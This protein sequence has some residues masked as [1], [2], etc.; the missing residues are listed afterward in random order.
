VCPSSSPDPWHELPSSTPV[1]R[2]ERWRAAISLLSVTALIALVVLAV[3]FDFLAAT[4]VLLVVFLSFVL[5]YLIAPAVE[6][7]RRASAAWRKGRPVTREVAL[8][9]LYG[10]IV[11]LALPVWVFAGQRLTAAAGRT[12]DT[13]PQHVARF[14]GQVRASE[15]WP[16]LV[17][18]PSGVRDLL[19]EATRRVSQS[20]QNEVR[21][22]G[23]EL[24]RVRRLV[25]WLAFVP[26]IAFVL[27][28]R[29]ARFRRSTTRVLPTAHLQWRADQLLQQVNRVLA[30]Y[31]RAQATAAVIVGV[32]C[33]VG[34][35]VLR[36]PYPGT[37]GL[38][39]GV[40]EMVPLAGPVAVAVAATAMAP[41][42][43]L[44]VLMFLAVLRILQDYAIYP[45]I[46]G[47]ATRLHPVAVVLALWLG[48]AIG[49]IIGLCLAVP[50]VG[51]LQVTKRHWREYHAIERL[52]RDPESRRI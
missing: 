13:V 3:V 10:G 33:W 15:R 2:R 42:R 43:A 45:R 41:E 51:A 22:L 40:L 39:A 32:L 5:T 23:A 52:I 31:I 8:L 26:A 20:V 21:A 50:V 9:A 25:P 48:A 19:A 38:V 30:A 36:L 11:A 14:I 27:L 47:R 18:V 46:I 44:P 17:G 4:G 6:R 1:T 7:L 34:F 29:W 37:L 24:V 16:D 28:T 12:V 35:A 49:G